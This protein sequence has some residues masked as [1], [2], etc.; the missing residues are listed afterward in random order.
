MTCTL[1]DEFIKK[2]FRK[3]CLEYSVTFNERGTYYYLC[4][5]FTATFPQTHAD[6]GM[7]GTIVVEG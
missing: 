7:Y 2:Y 3:Q 4:S 5:K 1:L 6:K